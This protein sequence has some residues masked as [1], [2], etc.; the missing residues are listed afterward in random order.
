M[1]FQPGYNPFQTQEFSI[2]IAYHERIK[3]FTSKGS[4]EG[5]YE[6]I[7]GQPFKRMIDAWLLAVALGSMTGLPAL[8]LTGL[9]LKSFIT[10]SVLQKDLDAICFLMSIAVS[11]TGDAYIVDNPSK[12]IKIATGFAELGFPILFELSKTGELGSTE[13]LARGLVKSLTPNPS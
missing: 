6:G 8:D 13:N 2:N 7:S 3:D 1:T 10:G 4:G 11:A 9:E 12:M 5:E